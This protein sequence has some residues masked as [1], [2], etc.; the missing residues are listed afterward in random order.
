MDAFSSATDLDSAIRLSIMINMIRFAG[1][2]IEAESAVVR[3][4]VI[5]LGKRAR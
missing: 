1:L 3:L 5:I 2:L 4:I